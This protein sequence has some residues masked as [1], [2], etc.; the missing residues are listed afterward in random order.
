[1]GGFLS[2]TKN[3]EKAK[4]F[5]KDLIEIQVPPILSCNN[6]FHSFASIE[7]KSWFAI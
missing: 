6:F 4:S 2:T 3:L 5:G 7:D 1:M